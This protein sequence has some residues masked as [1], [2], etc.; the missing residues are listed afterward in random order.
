MKGPVAV[1]QQAGQS[2]LIHQPQRTER[3]KK[4][5]NWTEEPLSKSS[6]HQNFSV[7]PILEL[8]GEEEIKGTKER[9]RRRRNMNNI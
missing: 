4:I 8:D 2:K 1:T 6:E 9:N 3:R 7:A 5:Q